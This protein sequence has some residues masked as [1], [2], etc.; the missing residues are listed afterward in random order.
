[1]YNVL[2]EMLGGWQYV[3]ENSFSQYFNKIDYEVVLDSS[4][5]PVNLYQDTPLPAGVVKYAV[6][7]YD[8]SKFTQVKQGVFILLGNWFKPSLF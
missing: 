3:K 6:Q 2:C 4:G 8:Q 5:Q 1:M 7:C